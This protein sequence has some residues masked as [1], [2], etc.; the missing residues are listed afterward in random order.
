MTAS[1][2]MIVDDA[3]GVDNVRKAAMKLQPASKLRLVDGLVTGG[4]LLMVA[5]Y[6]LVIGYWFFIHFLR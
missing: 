3:S 6:A 2:Y 1:R 4:I 5:G